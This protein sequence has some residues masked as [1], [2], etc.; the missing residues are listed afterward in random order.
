MSL[1][2]LPT[3]A[4]LAQREWEVSTCSRP[5]SMSHYDRGISRIDVQYQ[6]QRSKQYYPFQ[7]FK[8]RMLS[9]Q[10]LH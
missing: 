9:D 2:L 7:P 5:C 10:L 8:F 6:A 4:R 1:E 3:Q